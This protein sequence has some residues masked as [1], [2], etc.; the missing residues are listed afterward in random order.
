MKRT[1]MIGALLLVGISAFSQSKYFQFGKWE[2]IQNSIMQKVAK[3]YVDSIPVDKMYESG[4]NEMLSQ[5][6]PYTVYVPESEQEDF[7]FMISNTYGGIGAVISKEKTDG[8]IVVNEPYDNTPASQNGLQCGD[9]ILSI[10]GKETYSLSTSDATKLLRGK[11][12]SPAVLKVRKVRSGQEVEI[13]VSRERI[14]LPTVNYYGMYD[15]QTGYIMQ[16]GFVDGTSEEVSAAVRALKES[17]MKRL[18]LDLRNNGGGMLNEAVKIISLF[19][20]KGTLV[21]SS[22]GTDGNIDYYTKNDPIDTK[23]PILVLVN[24]SSASASE[25]VAGAIQD[26]DRGVIAGKRTFGKGLVQRVLPVDYNGQLKVTIAKYYTPSG[27]CVQAKDYS[28]RAE[29]GSVGNIPDSLTHEFKTAKGRTVRD[30]GGITPDFELK[31]EKM[32]RT[33]YT[34]LLYGALSNWPVQF[35]RK[36]ES[37]DGPETF[38]LSDE[39]YAEFAKWVAEQPYDC[40]TESAVA[41]DKLVNTLKEDKLYDLAKTSLDSLASSINLDEISALM[42]CK[43]ELRPALE[44]EVVARYYYEQGAVKLS[45]RYD[46]QLEEALSRW[47]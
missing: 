3:H 35:C 15:D 10:D 44:R 47:K 13:T 22:R 42:A 18:V 40:R 43:D 11:A 20:P 32:S 45:L 36:H 25:I 39:D 27:R 28:H 17:G 23:L 24:S 14:A 5:L 30:G 1:V 31:S 37:I 34:C 16:S 12:G 26:L 6:D 29:D 41:Y 19:V 8:P 2:E 33:A 9:E 4:I 7:E 46:T 38:K 21:V